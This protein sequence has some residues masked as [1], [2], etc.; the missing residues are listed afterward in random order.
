MSIG[1]FRAA[2]LVIPMALVMLVGIGCEDDTKP[3]QP[4]PLVSHYFYLSVEVISPLETKDITEVIFH[5]DDLKEYAYVV[6]T[7]GSRRVAC[8]SGTFVDADDVL[9]SEDENTLTF[10][11]DADN[12]F[13]SAD[14]NGNI[15]RF[16]PSTT[17][18][19]SILRH[20]TG[21]VLT[22][23]DRSD[24]VTAVTRQVNR[25]PNQIFEA[26]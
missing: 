1:N 6:T 7:I 22:G 16:S 25:L 12:V 13:E 20:Q 4:E 24:Y 2:G 10:E 8:Q 5:G 3:A 11:A 9:L 23:D 18:A 21:E 17:G 15:F 19:T 26:R 14:W